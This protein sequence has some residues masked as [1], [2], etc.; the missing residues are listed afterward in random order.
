MPPSFLFSQKLINRT[1]I[2]QV[3]PDSS[4]KSLPNKHTNNLS[5]THPQVVPNFLD[6][7]EFGNLR[8]GNSSEKVK[9]G[10]KSPCPHVCFKALM[11]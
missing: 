5:P 11:K 1:T 8:Y 2:L 9:A 4:Q 10:D 7:E 6:N 3:Y